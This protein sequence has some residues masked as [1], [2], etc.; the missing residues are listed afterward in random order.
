VGRPPGSDTSGPEAPALAYRGR[1][2]RTAPVPSTFPVGRLCLAVAAVAVVWGGVMV[3]LRHLDTSAPAFAIPL[4]RLDVGASLLATVTAAA[5]FLRWRLEGTASAF[6][7]GLATLVLG[8]SGFLSS[9]AAAAYV[10]AGIACSIVTLVLVAVWLRGCEVD[11]S[12][13]VRKVLFLT[14]VAL[15]VAVGSARALV[16]HGVAGPP[17]SLGIGLALAAAAY[18][19][20]RTR[21]RDRWVTVVLAAYA[22]SYS[23]YA[24][25]AI[26]DPMRAAGATLLHLIA[27]GVAAFGSTLLL[28]DA[29][30]R[31]RQTAFRLRVERDEAQERFADTLHEVRSTVT[32]LEGGVRTFGPA[33]SDPDQAVLSRALVAEIQRLRALVDDRPSTPETETFWV[34]DVLEPMLT[35][36]V[37]AG[38]VLTWDIPADLHAV[39]RAADVAQVVHALLAN[40]H[41]H[42]PDSEID[43]AVG[44][45]DEFALIRVSD[46]GPGIDASLREAVF[47]RGNARADS[48]GRGLGLHIARTIAR[49][50][51][52]DLWAEAG[53]G[54]GASFVLT[55]PSV[56]VLPSAMR[57]RDRAGSARGPQVLDDHP[58]R[59][60]Q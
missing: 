46:H 11:A 32:A 13:S 24:F 43:I 42:A 27:M 3:A 58:L 5:C 21:S 19:T 34:L 10:A 59:S 26:V 22:A 36:C 15:F 7:A 35:V 51:G 45:E 28:H 57:E 53:P 8:C 37:A 55:V 56:T 48:E 54:G 49:S 9:E 17:L 29:A 23:V 4:D 16:D 2:R 1:D 38:W 47:E 60:A 6:W 39:G 20:H 44:R 31:Q 33:N 18:G 14:L 41:R 40:A 50:Q 52:G 25:V 12:L 30:A